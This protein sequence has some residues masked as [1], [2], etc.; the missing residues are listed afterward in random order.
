MTHFVEASEDMTNWSTVLVWEGKEQFGDLWLPV[1]ARAEDAR[2]P[3]AFPARR[4]FRVTSY[5]TGAF[6]LG[7]R[8]P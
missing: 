5:S 7:P 3:N 2:F 8:K 1:V 4:F 6:G